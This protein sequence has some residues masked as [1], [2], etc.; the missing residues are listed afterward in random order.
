MPQA[1]AEA[2]NSFS[3]KL[4][5]NLK[6]QLNNLLDS[7]ANVEQPPEL[8]DKQSPL[9][10]KSTLPSLTSPPSS[11]A[12]ASLSSSS[13]HDTLRPTGLTIGSTL[14]VLEEEGSDVGSTAVSPRSP[15][16]PAMPDARFKAQGV[17]QE[18]GESRIGLAQEHHTRLASLAKASP[19]HTSQKKQN[20]S[21]A[22]VDSS[23]LGFEVDAQGIATPKRTSKGTGLWQ[24]VNTEER[25]PPT[26]PKTEA[27]K[28]S[29]NSTAHSSLWQSRRASVL[30]SL[31]NL[32][33]QVEQRLQPVEA[34]DAGDAAGGQGEAGFASMFA[35]RFKEAKENASDLLREAER[36]LGN[37]MTIDDLVMSNH[38]QQE[39]QHSISP[40][41]QLDGG[42]IGRNGDNISSQP[43]RSP[44]M[45][46]R[47]L[48]AEASPWYEAAGGRRSTETHV[49]KSP[50]LAPVRSSYERRSS[51]S[52]GRSSASQNSDR[53]YSQLPSTVAGE[54]SPPLSGSVG[55]GI[56]G[57]LM[58]TIGQDPNSSKVTSDEPHNSKRTS[59]ISSMSGADSDSWNWGAKDEWAWDGDDRKSNNRSSMVSIGLSDTAT[60]PIIDSH[61]ASVTSKR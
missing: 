18:Q 14:G 45:E 53:I 44:R 30:G 6:S 5:G 38:A 7:I 40:R 58:H 12:S 2:W 32:Q 28:T 57:L 16:S 10:A 36:K 37:A 60:T 34:N 51:A 52:S 50:N 13:P 61:H 49:R 21:S 11:S 17:D 39:G 25:G 24:D 55:G 23:V 31:T 1:A 19:S 33:K 56:Y 4:P 27:V 43:T 20:R 22:Y 48:Q 26:P 42:D 8:P 35:R 47:Q 15:L 46:A 9:L 29:S 3:A 59:T 41:I 54:A